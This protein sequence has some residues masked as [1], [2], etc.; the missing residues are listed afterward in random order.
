M[1]IIATG[2]LDGKEITV[3]YE[4]GKITPHLM[5]VDLALEDV[6]PIG[7]TFWPDILDPRNVFMAFKDRL[8]DD[9]SKIEVIGEMKPIPCYDDIPD[10][11]Y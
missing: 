5:A 11:V 10:I 9:E 2:K 8:F 6:Q 7:G 1:K 3:T 4:D